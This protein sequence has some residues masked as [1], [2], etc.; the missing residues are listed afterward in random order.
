ML[1]PQLAVYKIPSGTLCIFYTYHLKA[2]KL[3]SSITYEAVA[4]NGFIRAVET[5]TFSSTQYN[6]IT[7]RLAILARSKCP[8]VSMVYSI[9][10]SKWLLI[11]LRRTVTSFPVTM[12][13]FCCILHITKNDVRK[14]LSIVFV[15]NLR[16]SSEAIH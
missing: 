1:K 6:K 11:F 12:C 7:S 5:N 16:I 14:E 10:S 15:I 2:V 13:C 8:V 4:G 9:Q 3:A